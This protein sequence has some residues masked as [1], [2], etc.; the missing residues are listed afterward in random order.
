MEHELKTLL[1]I[2]LIFF[3]SCKQKGVD[4]GSTSE[5]QDVTEHPIFINNSGDK[6]LTGTPVTIQGRVI[7]LK[8]KELINKEHHVDSE[9][10]IEWR[11]MTVCLLDM[12]LTQMK[13]KGQMSMSELLDGGTWLAG[14][15]I[16][17]EKRDGS[18]PLKLVLT[19]I[20]F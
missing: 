3:F 20:V 10:I 11:A 19:G 2:F 17:S 15:Q 5:S 7:E 6:I 8:D 12:L 14:R 4:H 16:A 9:L 18:S 13:K 1:F